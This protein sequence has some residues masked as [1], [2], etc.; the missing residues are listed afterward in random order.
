[1]PTKVT[2]FLCK[3]VDN[4]RDVFKRKLPAQLSLRYSI[5]HWKKIQAARD[6]GKE[7]RLKVALLYE[8][9]WSAARYDIAVIDGRLSV[10]RMWQG[11]ALDLSASLHKGSFVYVMPLRGGTAQRWR[12]SRM[13]IHLAPTADN[14]LF[15]LGWMLVLRPDT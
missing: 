12:V 5:E 9:Q 10:W 13:T 4:L 3:P 7:V 8:E 1:M 11:H 2:T 15:R 6:E 14:E